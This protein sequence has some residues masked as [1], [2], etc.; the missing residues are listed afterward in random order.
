MPPLSTT[1]I[2]AAALPSRG[3]GINGTLPWRLKR[4]MQYFREVTTGGVVIM[5]RRTWESIPA[6]FRPLKD[7]LNVV[8]SRSELELPRDCLSAKSLDEALE[9]TLESAYKNCPIFIIGGAQLYSAALNHPTTKRILLTEISNVSS[10]F[11]TFF[12]FSEDW[13]K[14]DRQKLLSYLKESTSKAIEVPE[15]NKEGDIAYEFALYER[16]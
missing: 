12:Q 11:D 13:V 16:R 8:I 10:E 6:R 1:I 5:G 15:G 7:R 3:I 9:K 14:S 4:E 2:V